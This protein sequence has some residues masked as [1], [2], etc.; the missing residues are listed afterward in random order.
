VCVGH[1]FPLRP[2]P[3]LN[4]GR[5]IKT[6]GDG[7]IAEFGSVVDA[8]TFAVAMQRAIP[9]RQSGTAV[10]RRLIFRV[11]INLDYGDTPSNAELWRA[12]L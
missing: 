12:P 6:M 2:Q 1:I 9:E 7:F 3:P 10:E 11:G 5:M 4:K 8:V